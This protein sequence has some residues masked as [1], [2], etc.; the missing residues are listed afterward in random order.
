[1]MKMCLFFY[2]QVVVRPSANGEAVLYG[3]FY[4]NFI[5]AGRGVARRFGIHGPRNEPTV[6]PAIFA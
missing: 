5:C 4:Q 3:V 6:C 1:M 2:Q